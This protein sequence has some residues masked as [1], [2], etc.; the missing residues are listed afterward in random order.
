M[1]VLITARLRLC[2]DVAPRRSSF[3]V[4]AGGVGIL[5]ICMN[6]HK[7][8]VALFHLNKAKYMR[9]CHPLYS[10]HPIH[11][12]LYESIYISNMWMHRVVDA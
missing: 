12:H 10:N 7:L 8:C 11:M 2:S 4:K 9:F 3:R 5:A 1:G 6:L